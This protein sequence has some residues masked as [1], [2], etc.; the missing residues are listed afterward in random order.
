MAEADAR[1]LTKSRG[2]ADLSRVNVNELVLVQGMSDTKATLAEWNRRPWPVFR[3]WLF[4]SLMVAF[5]LLAATW[6]VAKLST[7]DPSGLVLPGI[8]RDPTWSDAGHV[9]FRNSLVLALHSM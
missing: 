1:L 8:S 5:G 9:L 7:P 4:W 6:V 3:T 2:S